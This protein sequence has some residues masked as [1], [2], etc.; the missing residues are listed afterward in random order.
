MAL[1]E[2]REFASFSA[3]TQ[4]YVRRS[5]GWGSDR[6]DLMGYW[7]A[8]RPRQSRAVDPG[9][10]YARGKAEGKSD[11]QIWAEYDELRAGQ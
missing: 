5:L 7:S 10:L 1:A 2:M 8:T 3:A 6:H 4:R 11:E 9:P